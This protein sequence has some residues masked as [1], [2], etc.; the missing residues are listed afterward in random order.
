AELLGEPQL[1][2]FAQKPEAIYEYQDA[3]GKPLF[4]KLRYPGK[5]FTQ[6][7]PDEK[8][9]WIY[10]LYDG[11]KP[12]YHLP[13]V[14]VANY[15]FI[16]EGEK[17]ADNVRALNL[18]NREKSWFFASTTN[19]DGAGKWREEY[20]VFFAGKRVVIF[21][22]NDEP[23]RRHA[24]QVAASV[25]RYATGVKVVTLPGLKEKE[26]VSD[27]LETGHN[28]DDLLKQVS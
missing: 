4:Q 28:A 23:G 18:S 7:K 17:D 16:C 3:G 26:D 19:F 25:H 27:W 2:N 6:R 21:P 1:F 13:E 14:L 15:V 22:D 20:S 10:K 5:R 12:L 9:G 24:E 11:P 8:G